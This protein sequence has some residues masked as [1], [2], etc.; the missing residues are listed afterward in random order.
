[1]TECQSLFCCGQFQNNSRGNQKG[2]ADRPAF[3]SCNVGCQRLEV[4]LQ[5]KLNL[6]W[7]GG[8]GVNYARAVGRT[9]VLVKYRFV[10]ERREE[11]G[12]VKDIEHFHAD[13]GSN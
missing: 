9:S 1:M 5:S 3:L 4:D 12:M 11:A 6:A 8:R 10:V 7:I 13:L 2:R